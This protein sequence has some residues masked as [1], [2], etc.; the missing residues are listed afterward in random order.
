MK[1]SKPIYTIGHRN[2]DT[3]SICSAIGY[4]HLKRSLGENVESARAGKINAETKY[5]LET[6]KMETPKLITDLY[7][8]VKDVTLDCKVVV[9]ENDTLRTLGEVMRGN[10]IKSVP[11]VDKNRKLIGIVTVSDLAKRYFNELSMQNLAE[12]NVTLS[13]IADVIDGEVINEGNVN[14]KITGNVRIAAGSNNTIRKVIKTGDVVLVGDRNDEAMITCVN[15]NIACLVVTGSGEV[16]GAVLTLAEEKN[17]VVITSPYDTY[18]CA[19]LVNQ[20]IPVSMIMQ[21]KLTSFKPTDLLSDIKETME[22]TQFRNYPVVENEKLVGVVSRDQLIVPERE[23]VIL[24]DHNERTQAVEGIEEAKIIE[25][26]DHHRLGGLQTSEPIFT[27]QE[28]VGCTATIVANMYWHRGVEMPASIAGLLLSAII[29]DTVLFK[30]PTCTAIDKETAEKL[31]KIADV[32]IMKHGMALLKAGSGIG[33]MSPIEVAKNDLKEFQ[34]GDYRMIVSQISV[35][36]TA[37]VL[38]IKDALL[39][40]MENI[41]RSEGYDMSLL[42]VTDIIAE[43]TELL[44]TG[45]P[46]TVI[47][48]AFGKSASGNLISLPGVMSR[49]KQII[50]PMVEAAGKH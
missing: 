28:P 29:S 45:K 37:E 16:S 36:D 27:R 38:A 32:D 24:V 48:E 23:R 34:I 10:D 39:T 30:S 47:A 7:P 8:R 26:I 43:G 5:V 3:D 33:D 2:P 22:S 6:F 4:A 46:K 11:V 20:C 49:K 44:F 41:C 42:M 40:C 35:M 18:T 13:S 17:L 12:A 31:A 1:A 14:A 9:K 21:K 25:I 19:R 50:P 15:Q